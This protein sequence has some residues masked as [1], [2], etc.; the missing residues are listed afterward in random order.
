MAFVAS[1]PQTIAII[2]NNFSAEFLVSSSAGE[3]W[4]SDS[5]RCNR[6]RVGTRIYVRSFRM[7]GCMYE[8]VLADNLWKF[9]KGVSLKASSRIRPRTCS[10][11]FLEALQVES[12]LLCRPDPE[13]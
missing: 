11:H 5:G 12:V 4:D 9:R 13:Q 10:R 8:R 2:G 7:T 6:I 3:S 1:V